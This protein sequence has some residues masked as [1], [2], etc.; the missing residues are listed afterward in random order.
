MYIHGMQ[1]DMFKKKNVIHANGSFNGYNTVMWS[2]NYCHVPPPNLYL[3]RY[4]W[5]LCSQL[6]IVDVIRQS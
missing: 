5:V 6:K 1:G 2:H 3:K 4:Q